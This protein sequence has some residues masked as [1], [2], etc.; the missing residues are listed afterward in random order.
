MSDKYLHFD[1]YKSKYLK[2]KN[3]YLTLKN[4][5]GGVGMPNLPNDIQEYIRK[6]A[7]HKDYALV[8]KMFNS[9]NELNKENVDTW[10]NE[11]KN[12]FD[13]NY[14][15][16][17]SISKVFDNKIYNVI[18]LSIKQKVFDDDKLLEILNS[19]GNFY[20]IG[21]LCLRNNNITKIPIKFTYIKVHG[22]LDLRGNNI[23]EVPENFSNIVSDNLILDYRTERI[24]LSQEIQQTRMESRK[25]KKIYINSVC[26]YLP[27]FLQHC[28][29]E[30]VNTK[31][32]INNNLLS[33]EETMN[34]CIH[35]HVENRRIDDFTDLVGTGKLSDKEVNEVEEI[36]KVNRE[37]ERVIDVVNNNEQNNGGPMRNGKL[38]KKSHYNPQYKLIQ[39]RSVIDKIPY[40][41]SNQQDNISN[42]YGIDFNELFYQYNFS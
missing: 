8:S 40:Y 24:F 27:P 12:G 11:Y 38:R 9:S 39:K 10:F 23:T 32:C 30:L 28:K 31:I 4:M 14:I 42:E 25:R 5:Y 41:F 21:N 16:K 1:L 18:D 35:I 20:I 19:L 2:Y 29:V 36:R 13:I 34:L 17:H 7:Q 6:T 3:K 26:E 33:D 15:K 37:V 22:I